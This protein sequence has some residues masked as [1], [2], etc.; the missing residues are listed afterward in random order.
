MLGNKSENTAKC[1]DL[2]DFNLTSVAIVIVKMIHHNGVLIN[3]T[4][5]QTSYR[6]KL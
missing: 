3:T 6:Q 4:V 2:L 1:I 5:F